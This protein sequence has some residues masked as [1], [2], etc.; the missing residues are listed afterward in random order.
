MKLNQWFTFWGLSRS[1]SA[2]GDVDEKYPD[3]ENFIGSG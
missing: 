2:S 3:A 1:A